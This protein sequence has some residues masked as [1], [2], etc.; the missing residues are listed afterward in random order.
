LRLLAFACALLVIATPVIAQQP[1]QQTPSQIAL[2]IDNIINGWAQA[3]E[4]LQKQNADL[5]AQLTAVTKER[6]D[7]KAKLEPGKP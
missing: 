5:Q 3:I 7:L 4:A 1:T 2:Q 6:D